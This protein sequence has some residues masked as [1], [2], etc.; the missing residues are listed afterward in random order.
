MLVFDDRKGIKLPKDVYCENN[1]LKQTLDQVL[2]I[3]IKK[4]YNYLLLSIIIFVLKNII[5]N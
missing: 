1:K 2:P 5:I 4:L 3:K